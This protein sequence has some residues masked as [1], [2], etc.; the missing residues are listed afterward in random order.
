MDDNQLWQTKL[1]A[2]LHDPGE[3]ALVLMRD[4]AGH[5]NGTSL[6]LARLSGLVEPE[7]TIDSGDDHMLA[8]VLFK[9]G[10][11]RGMYK[12]IQRADWWAA[13]AD[14]PQWPME[15]ITVTTKS[16]HKKTL[17]VADWAQVRWTKDPVLIHPLTG[18]DYKLPGGLS[19]TEIDDIKQR[20]FNHFSRLLIA[21]DQQ[22]GE[23]DWRKVLLAFWRFGPDLIEE[24]DFGKLGELW[25]L[26][27][28]DT[29]VPDHSIW[30][31][32]DLVSAF[33]GAF[34]ADPK[35]DAA[36]LVLS[37]G[38]VQSVIAA[39]RKTEDLWAGSH[40]LSRLAWEAMRP[41]CEE[42]GPDAVLFP[43]LR[44]IPQVDLWLCKK[45]GLPAELF[46]RCEWKQ[47]T[48]TDSNPLFS[49]ALPNRFVA[50]VPAS[51]A[52]DLAERCKQAVRDWLLNLGLTTMDTLLEA[53]G[54]RDAGSLRDESV[55]AYDQVR[56]Q[57]DGFPEVHWSAVPFSLITARNP[58]GQTDLDVGGLQQAMA[59]FYG[60]APDALAG[61]LQKPAWAVLQKE[62]S[63]TDAAGKKTTFFSPNPGV[64]YPAAYELAERLLAAAKSAREFPQVEQSGWRDSLTGEVEWLTT[65]KDQLSWP[66]G[67]RKSR[68]DP[69]FRDG[70]HHETLW[71]R[72]ADKRPA[73][74]RRGEHLGALSAIKRLWP[75]LFVDE[76]AEALELDKGAVGRFVVSTHTMA[77]AYQLDQ[78]LER[79]AL[80]ADGF[81]AAC[82]KHD[83]EPV[84]LPPR[85]VRRHARN[86]ERLR[87]AKVIPGLLDA[88]RDSEDE[89]GYEKARQIVRSSFGK[90]LG[91]NTNDVPI[92]TYYALLLMDGD[93]MG[94]ILSGEERH[95]VTYRE[96]LHPQV[97]RGF[98]E[99]AQRHELIA[100]YGAAKR[101]LSPNRHLAISSALNDFS[102]TVVR[103]VVES[104][105]LGR[106]IYAGGDDV[107]AML[108]VA[109]VLSC[110][111]R[112]RY[113]YSGVDPEHEGGISGGLTLQKGFAS[114]RQGTGEA[115]RLRIMR[116]MG[117]TATASCGA[118]IAHHQA[119]LAAVMRELRDAE[120]R[121]KNYQRG[122]K[123]GRQVD[124]DAFHITIIKRSGGALSV[125]AEWGE[126]LKLLSDVRD[127]L[128]DPNVSRRAVYHILE[129]LKDLPEPQSDREMLTKL[130][131]YQLA[132]QGVDKP[133]ALD[134]S[135]R[136]GG[137]A[138]LQP[139]DKREWLG[140]FLR[141]GEFLARES[142]SMSTTENRRQQ[143]VAATAA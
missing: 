73:W 79:G 22:G 16:G 123:A 36:L 15:E 51:R 39:A 87:D 94:R 56:R 91:T 50:I 142:R 103:H 86:P 9:D 125:T 55:H 43:R 1:A 111:Q 128:E 34:A 28:A 139:R 82:R 102:L 95:A 131:A 61:F 116:M 40:L 110:M 124:R 27:P 89:R 31:H 112:L 67:K 52:R 70:E 64:L 30:D 93:H 33:A 66:R 118:V 115:A 21:V 84:A 135:N 44:A 129:W 11:P 117:T 12:V 20:S 106:L 138:V 71:T 17:H 137:L 14:R 2:R 48:A 130:L 13:A 26:L 49:A 78:W 5:E 35:G 143:R 97:R 18:E 60:V 140:N 62:A 126:P 4:P 32:L 114:M 120:K 63:F 19:E 101:A 104:E 80:T 23:R 69:G 6:A 136:L 77:L 96:S 76:V 8:S 54:E 98:D 24:S 133:D 74:A 113:A 100:R 92:E 68:T 122:D 88:A 65:N 121:A 42:L 59:P 109:D 38:P 108:P 37:L 107:L 72:I 58:A 132:R 29:R 134:L 83:M 85:I 81:E 41:L 57:L 141:V 3:K 90:T 25:R 46:E 47:G 53:I 7:E 10:L 127:V 105:H 75:S 119:P 99:H 45:M